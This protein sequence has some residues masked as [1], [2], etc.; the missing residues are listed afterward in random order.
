MQVHQYLA[1]GFRLLSIILFIYS[2]R[3]VATFFAVAFTDTYG[4]MPA[5][6]AFFLAMAAIP[7]A[8]AALLWVF[9][10]TISK[11]VVPPESDV[12]VV[13]EKSFSILVALVLTVGLYTFFYASVDAIYWVTYSHLLSS[14]PESYDR[15]S[16]VIQS[17][18]ANMLATALEFIAAL[19]LI[20][21][22]KYIANFLYKESQ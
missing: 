12:S 5:S 6:P 1:I 3:Q 19:V 15:V 7:L 14:S 11:K 18:R 22:A 13:P 21:R 2:L 16:D 17:N 8:V 20:I 10:T 9:P 4:G